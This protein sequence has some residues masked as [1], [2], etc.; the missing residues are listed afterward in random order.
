MANAAM[1]RRSVLFE[2]E[3]K[4]LQPKIR[5][6]LNA[7]KFNDAIQWST[8]IAGWP[9]SDEV[10]VELLEVARAHGAAEEL[11]RGQRRDALRRRW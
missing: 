8:V 5:E 10:D 2:L 7:S 4:K 11:L 1:A 3:F 9:G 6:A